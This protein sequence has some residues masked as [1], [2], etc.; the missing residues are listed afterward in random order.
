MRLKSGHVPTWVSGPCG[1]GGALASAGWGIMSAKKAK[2]AC[3]NPLLLPFASIWNQAGERVHLGAIEFLVVIT[4]PLGNHQ[5]RKRAAGG[6]RTEHGRRT[7]AGCRRRAVPVIRVARGMDAGQ[8]LATAHE[9]EQRLMA[10]RRRAASAG[11]SGMPPSCWRETR[12]RI[13]SGSRP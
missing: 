4:I 1:T 9:V 7:T 5:R 3:V 13:A 2:S 10:R 11:S 12:R 8:A 6:K